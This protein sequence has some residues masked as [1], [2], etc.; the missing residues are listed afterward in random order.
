M[1]SETRRPRRVTPA[2]TWTAI[3]IAL[4]LHL[5]LLGTGQ[6]FGIGLFTG[7]FAHEAP[8]LRADDDSELKSSCLGHALL[9]GSAR[10]A[11]CYAPWRA[12]D[13]CF[14]HAQASL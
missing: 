11:L 12:P 4:G 1:R 8:P 2:T 10:I 3:G 5:A 7:A 9:A 6:A 14:D 13:T